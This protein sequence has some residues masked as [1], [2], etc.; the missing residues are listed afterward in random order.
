MLIVVALL[1]A[2]SL[3][4]I[5]EFAPENPGALFLTT[6]FFI[7]PAVIVALV[8]CWYQYFASLR[9]IPR[10][11]IGT[12]SFVLG[13]FLLCLIGSLGN[14]LAIPAL[15]ELLLILICL[16]MMYVLIERSA[17]QQLLL[18]KKWRWQQS[19][20]TGPSVIDFGSKTGLGNEAFD[21][22]ILDF[23]EELEKELRKQKGR[24]TKTILLSIVA[25]ALFLVLAVYQYNCSARGLRMQERN[26]ERIEQQEERERLAEQMQSLESNLQNLQEN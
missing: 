3:E 10:W 17:E 12:I 19:A 22:E 9:V 26:A 4:V 16:F 21:P 23:K 11:M 1:M 24:L 6:C 25:L 13:V 2:L 7:I 18:F 20:G 15:L 5:P 8:L 14:L